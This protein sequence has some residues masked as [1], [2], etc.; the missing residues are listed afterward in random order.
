MS[1]I[2]VLKI[3]PL[4][5]KKKKKQ[6]ESIQYSCDSG[7][8]LG[9]IVKFNQEVTD[10]RKVFIWL[11]NEIYDGD[12]TKTYINIKDRQSKSFKIHLYNSGDNKISGELFILVEF[13]C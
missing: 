9:F 13:F 1:N 12:Y 2:E 5:P 10:H 11:N 6:F 4:K 7:E 3:D 8:H